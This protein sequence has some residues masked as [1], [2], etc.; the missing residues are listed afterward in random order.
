MNRKRFTDPFMLLITLAGGAAFL[1]SVSH[2][3]VARLD[4]RFWLLALFTVTCSSRLIVKIPHVSSE[5]TVSDT[6]VFL[7]LLLYGGEAAVLLAATETIFSSWRV[8]KRMLT[9]VFNVSMM[10]CSTFLTAAVLRLIF[11]SIVAQA[12]K[13]YSPA[14]LILICLMALVQY[15]ANAGLATIRSAL[16][17]DRPILETWTNS[18]LWT[19]ITYFAGASAAAI[20]ARLIGSIGIYA[21]LVATPIMAIVYFTYRTY[22]RNVEVSHEKAIQAER[23]VAELNRYI[24]E[25]E[26]ISRALKESEEHFRSAFDQAAGM[27]LVSPDWRWLKVNQSLCQM[28]GYS[29]QE[30][31]DTSTQQIT[32]PEDLGL[33]ATSLYRLIE[34]S[35]LTSQVEKR[36]RSRAGHDVWVL[37]SAS[38]VRDAENRP[39]H[40]IFQIQDITD[41]RQAE[42]RIHH[43]AFHDALTGLP[44]RIL[45]NDR[46]SVAVERARRQ[47]DY[48]FAVL[49]IDLDRFKIVNDS[50]GHQYG[51]ELLVQVSKRLRHCVRAVD[52][53]ARLGGDEFAIL[54]DGLEGV[55]NAAPTADRIQ[56]QLTAPFNLC[57]QEVFISGSIGIAFSRSGYDKPED[58]LRDSDTAMYRAKSNGK[59]R[60]EFFDQSMH[61]EALE[62]LQLENDLRRAIE[63][64]EFQVQYQPIVSLSDRQIRGFE[65]LVRWHHPQRGLVPPSEFIPFAE[66]TGLIT[67]IG[68]F[69]LREACRQIAEWQRQFPTEEPLT[70]SVNLS[71]RQLKEADIAEQIERVLRDTGLHPACLR[72]EITEGLV[73]ENTEK[74]AQ[75]LA[76][77]KAIGVQLS[78]DD[79]GTGYS[80]LSYLHRF[81]FDILK[82]DRS[83]VMRMGQDQSSTRIV[84][85]ILL[86][87]S[88]LDMA[89]V[90][91]GVETESQLEHLCQLNCAYGQGYL[92]SKPLTAQAAVA[93][94]RSR[95][96]EALNAPADESAQAARA[97]IMTSSYLM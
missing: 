58:I 11:G 44:N 43:A 83:F 18:F 59:A 6:M 19:S 85:T 86:L 50:L 39:L 15:L 38:L 60:H 61:S 12:Q 76:R 57:G 53:V 35:L 55:E 54:L 75:I 24:A 79:F 93:I 94:L 84:K 36:Y 81:P 37:Q 78:L 63:R 67:L 14:F 20:I 1:W 27:A 33:D 49:F 4:L 69:V 48:Q 16:A 82:V 87:A 5:I 40:F 65:A 29:E 97:R 46:L 17:T 10:A 90:A 45:L 73:M 31:L 66:E 28:L 9:F 22:L 25:Q 13:D 2:L 52:T 68:Q 23:H 72:L 47:P 92:F 70:V 95:F 30:L 88:E 64:Q 71:P 56:E 74:A 91:E 41:R 89:V 42:E 8:S 7:T 62:Q 51:D 21:L 26:R 34:G 3:P 96:T 32:H 80:S 77:L